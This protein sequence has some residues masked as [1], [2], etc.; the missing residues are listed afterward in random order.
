[1]DSSAFRQY[2]IRLKEVNEVIEKLDPAIRGE[3]FSLLAG[4]VTG[5]PYRDDSDSQERIPR[6]DEESSEPLM[7]DLFARYPD[8]K[9]SDNAI[10]IAAWLYSQYGSQGFKL[11]EMRGIAESVGLTVPTS[12]DM[13]LRQ[14]QRDGK[15]LFQHIGRSEF[16]PTV[17]GE[18]YLKKTYQVTKGTKKHAAEGSGS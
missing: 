12:L 11:D 3:A 17:H 4:Y 6:G 15:A 14:A 2:V 7:A 9:P 18:L 16:R 8:G 10:L 5:K 13:T 1:M